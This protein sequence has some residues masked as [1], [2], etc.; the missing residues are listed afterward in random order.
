MTDD[1]VALTLEYDVDSAFANQNDD[2][3]WEVVVSKGNE[4]A[5]ATAPSVREAFILAYDHFG[6]RDAIPVQPVEPQ[7]KRRTIRE[8]IRSLFS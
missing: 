5:T 2:G 6:V 1:I 3:S 7:P 4:K 8:L